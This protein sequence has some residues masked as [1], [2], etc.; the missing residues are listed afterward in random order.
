MIARLLLLLLLVGGATQA[1][2]TADGLYA[3][4]T[5]VLDPGGHTA[6]IRRL[7]TDAAGR[8]LVTASDDKTV[9]VWA[10]G[11]GR[12][13]R[14][15]RLPSGPGNVGKADAVAL[16][17]DGERIA[18]GGWTTAGKDEQ[19]YL[20]DRATGRLLAR[21]AALP[22]VAVHLAFAPD[23]RRLAVGLGGPNGLRVLDGASLASL[24]ADRE[25]GDTIVGA[26]FAADGR[27]ATS[28]LDGN[29]RL[30][31]PQLG[32]PT[33]AKAPG[34]TRPY[35]VAWA[36][37]GNRL[38]VGYEDT[39]RVD[40]LDG[41]TLAPLFAADTTGVA[42][43]SLSSVAWSDDG[44]LLFAAGAWLNDGYYA[45][46]HW[47]EG[48]R[49]AYGDSAVGRDTITGLRPLPGPQLAFATAE[50]SLGVLGPDGGVWRNPPPIA[51]L[52]GQEKALA[53][54]A[55][56]TRVAFGYWTGGVTPATFDVRA[57]RLVP[58]PPDP[59]LAK[60][61]TQ[62]LPVTSWKNRRDPALAGRLLP[63]EAY[64]QSRSLA[65]AHDASRFLLGT[66]WWLRLLAKDGEPLWQRPVPGIVWG[67]TLTPDSRLAVAAYG[68][69][70][71]RWHRMTDGAE[72]LAFFPHADQERWVAW[73]P[74]G[75]YM[76]SPG[77]ERLIGWQLNRGFDA[78][79]E[80]HPV[81]AF[82]GRLN[83]PDIVTLVLDELDVGR[84]VARADRDRGSATPAPS[85]RLRD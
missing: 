29:L 79:P 77:G 47:A 66:E 62:G 23:G 75:H 55:D 19:V 20:F 13:L 7:D 12:L 31:S 50:P 21:S 45:L 30:Y 6:I 68:D 40:V 63:L 1:Q 15:I 14:T 37:D 65:I 51:E 10:A 67:V 11:D 8:F 39:T 58:G 24:G 78:A 16:S 27:L 22:D 69:G 81:S 38:A 9:R 72:L 43:G 35:A 46:R 61:R 28:S 41:R 18:A 4:P 71:L 49:G 84:A 83:R 34:G 70:T 76:A 53:V 48:G 80:F 56:G 36:P 32:R 17:P 82:S 52:R 57:R 26:A 73:T 33:R 25:Y 59:T 60:A 2:E 85:P 74:V 3:E 64:E 42:N 44:V 54:A 5:L